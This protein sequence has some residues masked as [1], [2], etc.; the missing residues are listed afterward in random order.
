MTLG[1]LGLHILLHTRVCETLQTSMQLVIPNREG[2]V[3]IVQ[4]TCEEQTDGR[5][6]YWRNQRDTVIWVRLLQVASSPSKAARSTKAARAIR[7]EVFV[8]PQKL[9]HFPCRHGARAVS[10]RMGPESS[11]TLTRDKDGVNILE[12][13]SRS[14]HHKVQV[15]ATILC[16]ASKARGRGLARVDIT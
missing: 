15:C 4:A 7:R 14:C 2:S 16:A 3:A 6:I 13:V 9:R 12:S 11:S 10:S 8:E 5:I 1:L